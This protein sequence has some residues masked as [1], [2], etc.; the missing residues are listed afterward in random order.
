MKTADIRRYVLSA[1]THAETAL[2]WLLNRVSPT[3]SWCGECGGVKTPVVSYSPRAGEK[4]VP[5]PVEGMPAF[6]LRCPG[7]ELKK[8][9]W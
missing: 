9:H 6:V 4:R 2:L 1:R 7:C 8:N 5:H 3:R